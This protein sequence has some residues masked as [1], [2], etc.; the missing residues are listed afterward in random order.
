MT[1]QELTVLIQQLLHNIAPETDP[2]LLKPT[3]NIQA[4]LGMDSFDF[5]R[6]IIALS[7]KTGISVPEEDYGKVTTIASLTSY[8][9]KPPA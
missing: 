9:G 8:L 7:E 5:L 6:F 3:D 1:E 4:T 2:S